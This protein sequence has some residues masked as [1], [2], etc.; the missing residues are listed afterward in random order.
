MLS[1]SPTTFT[2]RFGPTIRGVWLLSPESV[3]TP[4]S[5][6]SFPHLIGDLLWLETFILLLL[7]LG[8]L[9]AH[10]FK[11]LGG[12]I[13]QLNSIDFDCSAFDRFWILLWCSQVSLPRFKFP[14][15]LFVLSITNCSA[16]FACKFVISGLRIAM[17]LINVISQSTT[18]DKHHLTVVTLVLVLHILMIFKLIV[19]FPSNFLPQNLRINFSA[20]TDF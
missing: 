17:Q 3:L 10:T 8:P 5:P 9:Y 4:W 19:S 11:A 2:P 7:N 20:F 15:F 13:S 14:K 16:Q 1:L 12:I 18:F 6:L